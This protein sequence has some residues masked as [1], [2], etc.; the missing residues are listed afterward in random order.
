MTRFEQRA[1]QLARFLSTWK[2]SF[3]LWRIWRMEQHQQL[4]RLLEQQQPPQ[5]QQQ[6]RPVVWGLMLE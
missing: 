1:C 2:M 3:Q 5:Q 4:R 6:P